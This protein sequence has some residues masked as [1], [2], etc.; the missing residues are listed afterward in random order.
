[1]STRRRFS[2]APESQKKTTNKPTPSPSPPPTTSAKEYSFLH[3]F[4]VGMVLLPALAIVGYHGGFYS[5]IVLLIGYLVT[6]TMDKVSIAREHAM[7]SVWLTMFFTSV[8]LWVVLF[9]AIRVSPWNLLLA[10][11]MTQILFLI[12]IW[13]ALRFPWIWRESPSMARLMERLLIGV[14]PFPCAV[15]FCWSLVEVFGANKAAILSSPVLSYIYLLLSVP[16]T[17]SESPP[18]SSISIL[19]KTERILHGLLTCTIPPLLFLATNRF[20]F[21]SKFIIFGSIFLCTFPF[22]ILQVLKKQRI[23][24]T[25]QSNYG[26]PQLL[27]S[28]FVV[29][30]AIDNLSLMLALV[31]L[32]SATLSLFFLEMDNRLIFSLSFVGLLFSSSLALIEIDEI[33][34]RNIQYLLLVGA[35]TLN[36]PPRHFMILV[37]VPPILFSLL[38]YLLRQE[39]HSDNH[40]EQEQVILPQTPLQ[41]KIKLVAFLKLVK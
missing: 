18:S 30:P 33:F 7:V 31:N 40:N 12:G 14:T 8:I 38:L 2:E 11:N 17:R 26:L 41:I 19:G 4:R 20:F 1:M 15:L 22:F 25:Y 5:Q 32:G 21:P 36:S 39:N 3:D 10:H 27:T 9:P 28:P 37:L 34:K 23:L 16:L 13:G 6:F 35:I 24:R 29:S